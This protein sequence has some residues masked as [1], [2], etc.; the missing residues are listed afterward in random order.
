MVDADGAASLTHLQL[1]LDEER[2]LAVTRLCE[3]LGDAD[4]PSAAVEMASRFSPSGR[5]WSGSAIGLAVALARAGRKSE[6]LDVIT[7]CAARLHGGLGLDPSRSL[8]DTE[9]SILDGSVELASNRPVPSP[10]RRIC[11]WTRREARPKRCTPS[12]PP[13]P[14]ADRRRARHGQV[15]PAAARSGARVGRRRF[16]D[17]GDSSGLSR[18][19]DGA[20]RRPDPSAR[21]DGSRPRRFWRPPLPDGTAW[22]AHDRPLRIGAQPRCSADA[23]R[24]LHRRRRRDHVDRDRRCSMARC[25]IDRRA[26]DR[27]AR[28]PMPI[29]AS[30]PPAGRH[31]RSLPT[32]TGC[33][34]DRP[35]TAPT[36]RHSPS[37]RTRSRKGADAGAD[38]RSMRLVD[39]VEERAGGNSL[40]VRLL[41]DRWVEGVR[42]STIG[43]DLRLGCG[44]T[45]ARGASSTHDRC[46]APRSQRSGRAP[47]CICCAV[48]V[49]RSTAIST[50]PSRRVW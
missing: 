47:V 3:L 15:G 50:R 48:C 12:V 8:L 41:L 7:T 11:W 23:R 35:G 6:A 24:R 38:A 21:L 1:S 33:R 49:R 30:D 32:G 19:R 20:D 27:A 22:C 2:W 43:A 17:L 46:A 36:N 18:G 31:G 14:S 25:R 26:V 44:A 42:I 29:R 34:P 13:T 16:D 5:T 10:P 28:P 45:T 37:G 39:S 9:R 40:F 4:D